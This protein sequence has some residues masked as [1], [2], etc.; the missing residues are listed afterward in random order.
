MFARRLRH[1]G[2]IEIDAPPEQVW[3]VIRP[4]ESAPLLDPR[5]VEAWTRMPARPGGHEV[6]VQVLLVEGVRY[7]SEFAVLEED[8]PRYART[9]WVSLTR[10]DP[11]TTLA[12]PR[13]GSEFVLTALPGGRTLY[14]HRSWEESR[15]WRRTADERRTIDEVSR[16]Q[17]H[18]TRDR[19]EAAG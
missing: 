17:L 16:E 7:R 14:E 2:R 6:Q 15:R 19:C 13:G 10:E 4:A 8:P 12:C 18:R 5:C 9:E 11:H 3:S 1:T